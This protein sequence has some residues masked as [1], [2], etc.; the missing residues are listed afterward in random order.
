MWI[1]ATSCSGATSLSRKPLAPAPSASN[2]YS[3]RSKVVSISTRGGC[4]VA[5]D[6]AGGSPRGRPSLASGCPSGRC[7][8]GSGAPRR[9]PGR[10]HWP[11]RR[12][13]DLGSASTIIR[14]PARTSAWSSAI[15]TSMLMRRP[16]PPSGR[17][18]TANRVLAD[19]DRSVRRLPSYS[20]TRSGDLTE[21]L[22]R[23]PGSSRRLGSRA[24]VR[25]SDSRRVTT[26]RPAR[27][28]GRPRAAPA[29]ITR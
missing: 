25:V 20:A 15:R 17:A 3:S 12:R 27:R 7:R 6:D 8:D 10:R 28:R 1:P 24:R 5:R 9:R 22:V 23:G 18:W 29:S 2:T 19:G 21:S 11:R 14:K 4:L 16:P 13:A 26:A